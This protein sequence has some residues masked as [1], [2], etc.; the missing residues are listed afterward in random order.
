MASLP[1]NSV[2]PHLIWHL[3]AHA[4]VSL[5]APAV[6]PPRALA[7]LRVALALPPCLL[8]QRP[9]AL[10]ALMIMEPME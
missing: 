10:G 8:Q 9:Q 2:A 7:S 5:R 3:G 6:E 4:Q 1:G